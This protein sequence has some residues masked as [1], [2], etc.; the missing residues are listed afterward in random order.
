M[1]AETEIR[2]AVDTGKVLFG[3]KN[4]EKSLQN[5]ECKMVVLA[6]NAPQENKERLAHYAEIA[7]IKSYLY[8]GTSKDLG[9][10]CGKPFTVGALAV[11]DKGK[12]KILELK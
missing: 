7:G 12:S 5:N 2:R 10:L 6:K 3:A 8:E 4:T 9:A 11:I 1:N